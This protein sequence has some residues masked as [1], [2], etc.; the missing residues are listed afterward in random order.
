MG[1]LAQAL[2][3]RI[4]AASH[5]SMNNIAMGARGKQNGVSRQWNYYETVGGGMGAGPHTP[6]ISAVQTHMTN[7]RNT[8][9]EVL[10]S[11][12]PVRIQ[13]YQIRANSGGQGQYSGGNGIQRVFEFLE[14]ATVTLLTERRTHAP[15]GLHGGEPGK[16]GDNL[17][18]QQH[19]QAKV[20]VRVKP[21]D[22][23]SVA[24]PGGGGWGKPDVGT[25]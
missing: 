25:A 16:T 12:Y 4:P 9:I 14:P 11:V 15:W 2:P 10:E 3:D 7:T 22:T 17:L 18:N 19:L 24:T 5:G 13:R 21:G 20:S 6:G 23:L 8:P 1:A